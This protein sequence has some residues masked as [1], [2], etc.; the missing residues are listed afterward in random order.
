MLRA[1]AVYQ[2]NEEHLRGR[3]ELQVLDL[4]QQSGLAA[5]EQIIAVPTL[6]KMLPPPLR[7]LI[8]DLSDRERV[9]VEL[10]L[11]PKPSV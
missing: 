9:L 5:G 8:G 10:D 4:T 1:R 6:I 11:K 3:Y 2:K 7:R